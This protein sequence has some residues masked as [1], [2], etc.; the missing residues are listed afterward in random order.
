MGGEWE[1]LDIQMT[2]ERETKRDEK[3][4]LE[5]SQEQ[6]EIWRCTVSLCPIQETS[7]ILVTSSS[8]PSLYCLC[9]VHQSVHMST[10]VC[11]CFVVWMT[12]VLCFMLKRKTWLKHYLLAIHPWFSL[13]CTVVTDLSCPAPLAR[14]QVQQERPCW[15]LFFR[16]AS[17]FLVLRQISW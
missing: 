11:F 13:S 7:I 16:G 10:H 12:V 14:S 2:W 9:L 8:L 4:I 15:K 17:C 1:M 3:R 5:L 6:K